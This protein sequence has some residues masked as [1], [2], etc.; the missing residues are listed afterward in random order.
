MLLPGFYKTMTKTTNFTIAHEITERAFMDCLASDIGEYHKYLEM[1]QR[2]I[3]KNKHYENKCISCG[4]YTHNAI[5]CP[6]IHIVKKDAFKIVQQRIQLSKYRSEQLKKAER[7]CLSS[8]WKLCFK[9]KR[10]ENKVKELVN[11]GCEISNGT[12]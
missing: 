3:E 9:D 4:R 11:N 1:K 7:N 8:N 10:L 5:N 2:F 6:R 12:I